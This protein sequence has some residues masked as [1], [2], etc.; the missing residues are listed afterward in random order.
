MG[1]SI[2]ALMVA[3][4]L[5]VSLAVVLPAAAFAYWPVADRYAWVSQG[6]WSG[7][8]AYDI[9]A[10]S[11][12]H[13]MPIWGGRVVFAGWKSNDCGGRQVW[14]YNGNGVYT[15][16]YHMSKITSWVGEWVASQ[17][18]T[19]GHV[20]ESGCATGPHVHVEVW[21]G[22]PWAS[23]SYRVSPWY[24]IDRGSWLPYR[25]R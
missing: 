19:I 15:T 16:Y 5:A 21:H 25:Y 12:T 22:K 18:T 20:G 6:Y 24:S 8:K 7:H 11:G 9:A 17:K 23:G 1:K 14:V 3:A 10:P 2:R 13:I 4:A